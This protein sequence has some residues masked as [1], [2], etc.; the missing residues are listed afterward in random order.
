[1][2]LALMQRTAHIHT[3]TPQ[4]GV[5]ACSL[6]TAADCTSSRTI[7]ENHAGL[8]RPWAGQVPLGQFSRTDGGVTAL[9]NVLWCYLIYEYICISGFKLLNKLMFKYKHQLKQCQLK[10]TPPPV[11][12]V[13]QMPTSE[14]LRALFERYSLWSKAGD[15]TTTL[16]SIF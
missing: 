1:M 13:P 5:T 6:P 15:K 4:L 8:V 14:K 3:I 12:S 11:L 16:L 9:R 2:S 7:L 10:K